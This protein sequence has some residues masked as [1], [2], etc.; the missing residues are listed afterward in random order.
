VKGERKREIGKTKQKKE[1][2]TGDKRAKGILKRKR[3]KMKCRG[4]G[5]QMRREGKRNG[6]K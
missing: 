3:E 4:K 5:R 6:R 1:R 2:V